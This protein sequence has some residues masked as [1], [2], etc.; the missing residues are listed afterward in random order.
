[1]SVSAAPT[2]AF[3][4]FAWTG[5]SRAETMRVPIWTPSAPSAKA[6]AIETP[7][8]MPPAAMIG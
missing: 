6:A 4:Q 8:Q 5:D 1:V 3:F 7:S 2:I